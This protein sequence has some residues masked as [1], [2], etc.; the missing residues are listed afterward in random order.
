MIL[1]NQRIAQLLSAVCFIAP[2]GTP[3][4]FIPLRQYRGAQKESTSYSE[5]RIRSR[6]FPTRQHRD[7]DYVTERA[8]R[9]IMIKTAE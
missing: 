6:A 1:S 3:T 8:Y 2:Q 5:H 7:K 4:R 9:D